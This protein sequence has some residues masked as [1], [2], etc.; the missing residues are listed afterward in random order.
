MWVPLYQRSQWSQHGCFLSKHSE[1]GID[2]EGDVFVHSELE[3][4]APSVRPAGPSLSAA[5]TGLT[6]VGWQECSEWA[7]HTACALVSRRVL[8]LFLRA[9]RSRTSA[10]K[11][12]AA[13][14]E[15]CGTQTREIS[16]NPGRNVDLDQDAHSERQLN[17]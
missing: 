16:L 15:S 11:T 8:D 9:G 12:I 6:E 2:S 1:M 10:G 17:I 14:D 7:D 4:S 3:H 13:M 5:P